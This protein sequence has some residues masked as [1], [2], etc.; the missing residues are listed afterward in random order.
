MI[1]AGLIGALSA[2]GSAT[3][4][5]TPFFSGG[6]E[7]VNEGSGLNFTVGGTNITNGT[8]YWT[9]ETNAGDFATTS[10]TVVVTGNSGTF[11]VTP[12]ADAATEG[13]ETFT[14]AL[15]EGSI[16]GTILATSTSVTIND[17]SFAPGGSLIINAQTRPWATTNATSTTYGAYTYPDETSGSLHTLTGTQYVL[18][19]L[20]GTTAT[21]CFNL[22][23]YPTA[24]NKIIMGELGQPLENSG[25]HYSILEITSANY[26]KGRVWGQS[27]P[28][29]ST[30]TVTLNAWN[31]VYFSFNNTTNTVSMSLNNETAVTQGSVNKVL[32]NT[33]Y[34]YWGIGL[35][36]STNMGSGARYQGKFADLVIDTTIIGSTYTATKAKYIPPL[37]LV[38]NN[39]QQDYLMTPASA[40]WNLGTT[41]TIEF[42]INANNSSLAGINIGGGQWGLFNQSGWFGGMA[43]NSIII[44]LAGGNLTVGQGTI[45]AAIE[46]AE[47]TAQQW[48]HVAV[49]NNGGGSAQKVYYNGAEQAKVLGN[50][51]SNGWTNT[52]DE[53]YI[54]RLKPPSYG[55]L[56]DGKL[57][58]VRISNTAKYTAGFTPVITYGVE[59]DTKLFLSLETPLVDTSIYELNGIVTS[60]GNGSTIYFSKTTY[61]N[62]NNQVKAGD[63]VV[64]ADTLASSTLTG[65]VYT[66]DPDNWGINISPSQP[67]GTKN[68]SGIRHA[69]TN[70]GVTTSA[71]VPTTFAPLSLN[72]VQS[73]T[74]YLDVAASGDWNLGTTWTIEF[75]SKATK[76]STEF[77]LLAVMCQ[78][79]QTA[80]GIQIMYIGGSLQIQGTSR[81]A[82]EPTPN[83]WT[84]VALVS[85]GTDLKLYYNGV[86]QYTGSAWNL[87]NST[88]PIRVGAR[89]T[90][91]FQRF[92]GLLAL[93]RISNTA[94]YATEFTPTIAYGVDADT[95][96]LLGKAVPLIDA[97][98]HAITNNGVTTST[99]FP[100]TFIGHLNAYSG[101]NLGA[102][103][104]ISGDPN[105]TAFSQIPVGARITSN[106]ANFGIRL[107]TGNGPFYGGQEITYDNTGLPGGTVSTTSDTYNFY[108]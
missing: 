50:Y 29:T 60:Q 59:A 55:G 20:W 100:Q 76:V 95:K 54:G 61:P 4:T 46:F 102:T 23:F 84:H 39:P 90:A 40:D 58:L 106:L 70:T 2:A 63:T 72:F 52:T 67:G 24:N 69:I 101:G 78:N 105:I 14:V 104:S 66:A 26:L 41:W 30:G 65:A 25:F 108:W 77:D 107:V 80:I 98:G 85:D 27:P 10:G 21:I 62:L 9:I 68:F 38:F 49:V 94:K 71:D 42:W 89:G 74:D 5:L 12:T 96:L 13:A 32:S 43:N 3:Y 34:S 99:G 87:N 44:G 75:W 16:T 88:N 86:G 93:I 36:D 45:D 19:E 97:K 56:F 47:P 73:Q 51:L 81:I 91:T 15:R 92:D 83:V 22:W 48:T 33:G 7:S 11:T 82:T 6:P 103:Y 17:T 57:A 35:V 64:D 1:L 79:Y 53:L 8:Y 31:H 37:S 18:S 28:V